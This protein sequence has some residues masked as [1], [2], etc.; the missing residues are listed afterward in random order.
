MIKVYK[1]NYHST[2]QPSKPGSPEPVETTDDSITLFWRA[3]DDDGNNEITEYVLE[4]KEIKS[5]T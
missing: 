2:E 3:P 4:Y 5:K 1:S